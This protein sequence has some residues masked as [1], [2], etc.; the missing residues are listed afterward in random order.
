[1]RLPRASILTVG[2]ELLDG[3][4]FNTN[5]AFLAQRLTDA[6]FMVAAT[7]TVA[8]DEFIIA[9]AI[10]ALCGRA[11]TVIVVGGLGPTHDDVTRSAL[12]GAAAKLLVVD[13]PLK[14]EISR[15]TKGRAPRKNA[16][17]AKIP[18]GAVIFPNPVGV[19]PGLKV[20][21]GGTPVYALPGVPMEMEAIFLAYVRPDLED[22]FQ[23]EALPLR[24]LRVFGLREAEVASKLEGV[25]ERG[26]GV[27]AKH[28]VVT[29]VFSGDSADK[30]AEEVY[31]RLEG[32]V[33]GEGDTTLAKVV[34]ELLKQ[35]KRTIAIAESVTGGMASSLFVDQPGASAV[36]LGGV[37]AYAT[38]TKHE[39]LGVPR[40]VL[41]KH[42]PAS[43]E[44]AARMAR[45]VRR[46]LGASIGVATTGVAG[47][48]TDERGVSVGRGFVAVASSRGTEVEKIDCVGDR[49]SVR[50]RFAWHAFDL[51]RRHLG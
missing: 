12:A 14:N 41:K 37:V 49:E 16:R 7:E 30:S 4:V 21:T 43:E 50:H 40:T 11:D 27:T 48:D 28:G 29:I 17:M 19:A 42:G 24:V 33:F 3:R 6:G 8:D 13:K 10:K 51:V 26:T 44:V 36:F 31:R 32:R 45:G 22:T 47:P 39:L 23:T 18:E 38:E 46:K 35:R 1:M 34:L 25:L 9:D 20:D 5:A 15:K 2:D